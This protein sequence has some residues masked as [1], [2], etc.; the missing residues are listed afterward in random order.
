MNNRKGQNSVVAVGTF[1]GVHRGHQKLLKRTTQIGETQNLTPTAYTFSLPPK[2]IMNSTKSS[3]I[4]P[5]QRKIQL[6]HRFVDRV[7]V[8]NFV[9]IQQFTPPQFM[10]QVLLDRLKAK[11]V[12]VG[13]D[14]RFGQDR[15]GSPD[16]LQQISK[17]L[18]SV[19]IVEP[20]T[21]K[22]RPVSSTWVR[23]SVREGNIEL[24]GH[25]LGRWPTF[26]GRVI[27]GQGIGRKLGFPTA[28]LNIDKK[29]VLPKTGIY[30]ALA[31]IDETVQKGVLY[32][33]TRPTYGGKETSLEIHLLDKVFELYGKEIEVHLVKFIRKDSKFS[34]QEKLKNAI[35]NDI[36]EAH[37]ALDSCNKD[38]LTKFGPTVRAKRR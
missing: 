28:N 19:E 13:P 15:S 1:D 3:L 37:R 29:I 33:G 20:V 6:L 31:R 17:N 24:A 34:S 36:K 27:E 22:G 4:L 35:Q 11:V 23:Q 18:L 26:F 2:L 32:V 7:C 16:L 9:E 5:S 12:V 38:Q 8:D 21:Y 25:L 10:K 14:W 30:A